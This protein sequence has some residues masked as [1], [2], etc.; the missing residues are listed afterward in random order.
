MLVDS[1][2]SKLNSIIHQDDFP[3]LQIIVLD[4]DG[5]TLS[6]PD[7]KLINTEEN[8]VEVEKVMEA[9][10]RGLS[11][12]EFEYKESDGQLRHAIFKRLPF[13]WSVVVSVNKARYS[14]VT[15]KILL[16]SVLLGAISVVLGAL[17]LFLVIKKLVNP[18]TS[19]QNLL[20][21]FFKYL[22]HQSDKVP[23]SIVVKTNDEFATMAA[24]INTNIEKVQKS[25]EQDSALVSGVV[26]IVNEAKEGRFGKTITQTSVNPQIN[27]LRD[28]LNEMSHTLYNFIGDNLNDAKG[29]FERFEANDFTPRIDNAQGLEQ[30]VNNLGDS[31]AHMLNVSLQHAKE[32]GEKSKELELAVCELTKS[33]NV[34]AN[35]LQ[36]T[37]TSV[38]EITSSMQS[39]S[40]RTSEVIAQSEDIKSVIGII[41][42]IA[43]QTNLLALNAAIEAARAGEHGRG[44][45]VVAD[46]VRKLAERTQKSLGEIEANTN[47]LVQSI[48]DMAESIKE[49]AQGIGQ[50][51]EAVSQLESV[52]QQNVEIAN[53]SQEISNAVD[54]IANKILDDVNKKRF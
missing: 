28:S 45:A 21:D 16:N 25:L 50:I 33:A 46:E 43:D 35:S 48:N 38:E 10:M 54:S 30:S 23:K 15:D 22:N 41:R 6:H 32:L 17:V 51:N 42:D 49:Q 14:A 27:I 1:L 12:G 5:R 19:I 2:Q 29:V 34:Q 20:L 53:H 18:I 36:Q 8:L 44:F 9:A 40:G 26:E 47:V 39:V 3:S 24:A 52:T 37:A 31:I 7:S 13:E 4:A 11:E